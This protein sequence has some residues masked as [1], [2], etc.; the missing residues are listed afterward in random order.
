MRQSPL[1]GPAEEVSSRPTSY[2]SRGAME[3]VSGTRHG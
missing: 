3:A 1:A 2:V